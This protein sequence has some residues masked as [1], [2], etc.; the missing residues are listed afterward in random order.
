[1]SNEKNMFGGE[2][3]RHLEREGYNLRERLN[4]YSGGVLGILAP[5]AA[6]RYLAFPAHFEGDYALVKETVVWIASGIGNVGCSL[7]TLWSGGFPLGWTLEAG[8]A[9]GIASAEHLKNNRLQKEHVLN[10]E[11]RIEDPE[12]P[13]QNKI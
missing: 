3:K 6:T 8:V 5:I 9:T 12:N 10:L 4:F 1:M 11:S 13:S 7:L 2:I